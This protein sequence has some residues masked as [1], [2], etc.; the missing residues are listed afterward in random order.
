MIDKYQKEEK[1]EELEWLTSRFPDGVYLDVKGLCK[2]V[3]Q[4]ELAENDYSLTPGRYVGVDDQIEEDFDYKS[5]MANIKK[6]LNDL[7]DEADYLAH[8]ILT[9]LED[10]GF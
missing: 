5:A 2:V 6:E 10:L 9:K 1:S 8:Q 7:N 3:I 4:S